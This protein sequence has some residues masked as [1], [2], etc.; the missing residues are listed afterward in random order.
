MTGEAA[1]PRTLK[2]SKV[3]ERTSL[4]IEA[5]EVVAAEAE[6]EAAEEVVA[7]LRSPRR[8][9]REAEAPPLASLPTWQRV[10]P[11]DDDD[12][13]AGDMGD[14]P[15]EGAV[16]ATVREVVAVGRLARLGLLRRPGAADRAAVA[17]AV[18]AVG[19]A[20]RMK[21]PVAA[22]SGGQQRRVL[23]ARALAFSARSA[24]SIRFTTSAAT[25]A[26]SSMPSLFVSIDSISRRISG[27]RGS[28][29]R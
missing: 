9:D 25:S 8:E 3:S 15:I 26:L 14:A 17:D 2:L 10:F 20:D 24:A 19:L 18:A 22:L 13:D 28:L 21:D 6:A 27:S 1:T 7:T 12:D 29:A 11:P 23:V 16:P 4:E 5:D